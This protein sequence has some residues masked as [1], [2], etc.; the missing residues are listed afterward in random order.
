MRHLNA[1]CRQLPAAFIFVAPTSAPAFHPI[2]N[3]KWLYI[4]FQSLVAFQSIYPGIRYLLENARYRNRK[5]TTRTCGTL[6]PS[7]I[8]PRAQEKSKASAKDSQGL[9]ACTRLL[10]SIYLSTSTTTRGPSRDGER[11]QRAPQHARAARD[12]RRLVVL[13]RGRRAGRPALGYELAPRDCTGLNARPDAA[14]DAEWL[15]QASE[16]NERGPP[17][18]IRAIIAPHAGFQCVVGSQCFVRS[19]S[20]RATDCRMR[21]VLGPDCSVRVPAYHG[22]G[23]RQARLHPGPVAPLLPQVSRRA[24]PVQSVSSVQTSDGCGR[25]LCGQGLCRVGRAGVR[26]PMR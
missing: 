6:A 25:I 11:Q 8:E 18:G 14:V 17:T 16:G 13:A 12:P 3:H 7:S 5:V 20:G 24:R 19:T 1:E 2:H 21:Q 10:L 4:T 23:P 15:R 26:D 22:P 9:G